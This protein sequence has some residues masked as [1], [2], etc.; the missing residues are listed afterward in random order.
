MEALVLGWVLGLAL[1]LP[2]QAA[3]RLGPVKVTGGQ[4]AAELAQDC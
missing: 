1:D 4:L 2:E 3:G